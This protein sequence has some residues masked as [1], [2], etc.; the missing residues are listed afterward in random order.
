M[1][2]KKYPFVS[3]KPESASAPVDRD[4]ID[5]IKDELQ[6]LS[7]THKLKDRKSVV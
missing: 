3:D 5:L 2:I 7:I 4:D 6:L 1:D